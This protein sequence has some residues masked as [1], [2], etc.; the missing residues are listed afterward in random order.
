MASSA[1]LEKPEVLFENPG[2]AATVVRAIHKDEKCVTNVQWHLGLHGYFLTVEENAQ[3]VVAA[4]TTTLALSDVDPRTLMTALRTLIFMKQGGFRLPESFDIKARVAPTSEY[5]ALLFEAL[6]CIE[7]ARIAF[8]TCSSTPSVVLKCCRYLLETLDTASRP[9]LLESIGRSWMSS[10]VAALSDTISYGDRGELTISV[11]VALRMLAEKRASMA[12]VA[13]SYRCIAK[14]DHLLGAT[15]CAEVQTAALKLRAALSASVPADAKDTIALNELCMKAITRVAADAAVAE[16]CARILVQTSETTNLLDRFVGFGG[17]KAAVELLTLHR[18]NGAVATLAARALRNG[19][20]Y[21]KRDDICLEV[22]VD[23]VRAAG[24]A[25]TPRPAAHYCCWAITYFIA[26]S[27]AKLIQLDGVQAIVALLMRHGAASQDIA[28]YGC[29][30][31]ATLCETSKIVRITVEALGGFA[32]LGHVFVSR[33]G[34]ESRGPH[35]L[36][37]A[38]AMK[39]FA[40]DAVAAAAATA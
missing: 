13:V 4:I 18:G 32:A 35:L 25:E 16:V 27:C 14:L 5:A 17:V 23:V 6:P 26:N 29:M 30:A 11:C 38:M 12:A 24:A 22:L 2:F 40:D 28:T 9:Q 3:R 34:F 7:H 33:G 36:Y 37:I 21:T 20:M 19:A 8:E 39:R 1:A 31:L 10:L 15:S